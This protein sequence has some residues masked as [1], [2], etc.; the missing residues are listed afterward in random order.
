M[1]LLVGPQ[2]L[3][4]SMV[5]QIVLDS[6]NL[7]AQHFGAGMFRNWETPSGAFDLVRA[8][9]RGGHE[10]VI[11]PRREGVQI[12]GES[13]RYGRFV[14][15]GSVSVFVAHEFGLLPDGVELGG[16]ILSRMVATF[17][18]VDT[19]LSATTTIGSFPTLGPPRPQG[20]AVAVRS[21]AASPRG[22]G[23]PQEE[24]TK[25]DNLGWRPAQISSPYLFFSSTS[26]SHAVK[27][28]VN[29][30]IPQ[31]LVEWP[32]PSPA[33]SERESGWSRLEGVHSRAGQHSL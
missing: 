8:W 14:L 20:G 4:G 5:F 11:Y 30:L 19:L 9:F 31:T 29:P 26:I 22:P 32:G 27:A 24:L 21:Q 33:L 10:V 15:G 25:S 18:V 28:T 16:V 17:G 2:E 7:Y 3:I 23:H 1:T 6:E 13:R 12:A